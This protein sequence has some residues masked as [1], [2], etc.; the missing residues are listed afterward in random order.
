MKLE[1]VAQLGGLCTHQAGP[2]ARP[3]CIVLQFVLGQPVVS[4]QGGVLGFSTTSTVVYWLCVFASLS[5][6]Q[7]SDYWSDPMAIVR[8]TVW[9]SGA[10]RRR[11]RLLDDTGSSQS[12]PDASEHGSGS[13]SRF[14]STSFSIRLPVFSFR[15]TLFARSMRWSCTAREPSA[16]LRRRCRHFFSIASA[17]RGARL[18]P[19]SCR[20]AVCVVRCPQ[21]Q[22]GRSEQSRRCLECQVEGWQGPFREWRE[23]RLPVTLT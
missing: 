9:G 1:P 6:V 20:L 14:R 17:H 4:T 23:F 5:V 16:H 3:S 22:S 13:I 8:L 18:R 21:L 11:Q 15:E 12:C 10:S 7:L 2:R 19:A